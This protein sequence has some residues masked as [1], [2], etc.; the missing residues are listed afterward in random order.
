MEE[1]R[2]MKCI[3]D[4]EKTI[5]EVSLVKVGGRGSPLSLVELLWGV[6][7][8]DV[9]K[10]RAISREYGDDQGKGYQDGRGTKARYKS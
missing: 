9:G 7:V 4:K 8:A 3:G 6:V 10:H 5:S 2:L 1:A